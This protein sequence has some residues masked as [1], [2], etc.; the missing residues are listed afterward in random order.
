MRLLARI[1]KYDSMDSSLPNAA[2]PVGV[3]INVK[4]RN[5]RGDRIIECRS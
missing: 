5:D 2:S 1:C 3:R 4:K